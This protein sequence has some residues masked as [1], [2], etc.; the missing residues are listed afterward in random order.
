MPELI[1]LTIAT[2]FIVFLVP[3]LFLL[4]PLRTFFK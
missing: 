4:T 1:H 3:A 2:L